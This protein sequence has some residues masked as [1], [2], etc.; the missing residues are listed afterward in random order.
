MFISLVGN[1]FD[2]ECSYN[3]L[4]QLSQVVPFKEKKH[5]T[6]QGKE[7]GGNLSICL[8]LV[9]YLVTDLCYFAKV[10]II[11]M[12]FWFGLEELDWCA[13]S[14]TPVNTSE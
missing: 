9:G 6:L 1:F 14:S 5:P 12:Y 10:C 7:N 13:L 4:G 3:K 8:Y 2:L 11:Y